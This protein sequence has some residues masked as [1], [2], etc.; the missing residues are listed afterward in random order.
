MLLTL[1]FAALEIAHNYQFCVNRTTPILKYQHVLLHDPDVYQKSAWRRLKNPFHAAVH[2]L[3][4]VIQTGNSTTF[5]NIPL[6]FKNRNM[7][8]NNTQ[9]ILKFMSFLFYV[10][11]HFDSTIRMLAFYKQ[12]TKQKKK[13]N[14]TCLITFYWAVLICISECTYYLY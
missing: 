11:L 4:S 13:H 2:F 8:K 10:Y 3:F 9:F 14:N 12:H 7:L 1:S 6:V 5:N